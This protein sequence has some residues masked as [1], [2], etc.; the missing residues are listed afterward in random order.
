MTQMNI[1]TKQKK[2]DLENRLGVAKWEKVGEGRIGKLELADA[3]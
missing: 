2:T 1:T 3:N